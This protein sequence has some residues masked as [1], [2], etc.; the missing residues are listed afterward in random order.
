M[1]GDS[2]SLTFPGMY[3]S[4]PHVDRSKLTKREALDGRITESKPHDMG[5]QIPYCLDPEMSE[6]G[7]V[8]G[9]PKTF[10]AGIP[11][12]CVAKGK[13]NSGRAPAAG[14]CSRADLDSPEV[15]GSTSGRLYKG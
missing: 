15:F 8:R 2:Q 14:S 11:G 3:E 4:L 7:V 10:R 13:Q 12:T 9:T 1:P 6:T 5:M